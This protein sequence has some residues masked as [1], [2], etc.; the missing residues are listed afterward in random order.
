MLRIGYTVW[1]NS[2]LTTMDNKITTK[3]L[4]VLIIS[5]LTE[6]RNISCSGRWTLFSTGT[7]GRIPITLRVERELFFNESI[8]QLFPD[9][10]SNF[11][12]Y[13]HKPNTKPL[14][15][16]TKDENSR[17]N[18]LLTFKCELFQMTEQS[19]PSLLT[20]TVCS[21]PMSIKR[22]LCDFDCKPMSLAKN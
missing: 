21:V 22:F 13:D 11:P 16:K 1:R 5:F 4:S 7:M 9:T 14:S 2:F 12:P 19:Y 6:K 10:G 17:S 8:M 20:L 18:N 15:Y 3:L